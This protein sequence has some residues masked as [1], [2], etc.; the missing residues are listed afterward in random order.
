[1]ID[2]FLIKYIDIQVA[3]PV[4]KLKVQFLACGASSNIQINFPSEFAGDQNPSAVPRIKV[5]DLMKSLNT[6]TNI[7]QHKV[8]KHINFKH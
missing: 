4:K 8:V 7:W 6:K 1:M 5:F 3:M 2:P